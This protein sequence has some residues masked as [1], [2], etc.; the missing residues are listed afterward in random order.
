MM[1]EP[2]AGIGTGTSSGTYL[3][4]GQWVDPVV[5]LWAWSSVAAT[6]VDLVLLHE[7][8]CPLDDV[9]YAL[10][11][12]LLLRWQDELIVNLENTDAINTLITYE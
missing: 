2:R 10:D 9:T 3:G 8:L 4:R 6:H 1:W 12:P 7:S 5:V 11:K